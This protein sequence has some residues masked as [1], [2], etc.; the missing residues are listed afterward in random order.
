[1][2]S[3]IMVS[4]LH[5]LCLPDL[6]KEIGDVRPRRLSAELAAHVRQDRDDLLIGQRAGEA[7]HQHASLAWSGMDSVE[8]DANEICRV[9]R[10]DRGAQP[11]FDRP[12]NRQL[13]GT[14]VAA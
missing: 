2:L 10:V 4:P 13:A 3:T 8:H 14:V 7:R 12:G 5:A 11:K 1:M 6:W 9:G